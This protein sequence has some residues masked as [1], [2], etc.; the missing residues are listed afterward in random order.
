MLTFILGILLGYVISLVDT[1]PEEMIT[2]LAEHSNAEESPYETMTS[3]QYQ[4]E[5][6]HEVEDLRDRIVQ[7]EERLKEQS[8]ENRVVDTGSSVNDQQQKLTIENLVNAGVAPAAAE[9][10]IQR[11]SQH[12]FRLL[13]LN[14]RAKRESYLNSP[15]YHKERRQL[16]SEAPSLRDAIGVDAYDRYLYATSQSNRVVVSAIMSGSPADQ[17]G[18]LK[19]DIVLS[20]ANEKVLTWQDLRQLTAKGVYGEYVNLAVLREQQLINILVPRGPLGV[21]L[22]TTK[23]DPAIEYRY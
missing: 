11:L 13:E 9:D 5:L 20:Y 8:T 18:V 3:R 6:E 16:L 4:Q 7:L 19:G 17:L 2:E 23:L 12:E 22:G 1:K 14:D 15:R 10:I 21:R